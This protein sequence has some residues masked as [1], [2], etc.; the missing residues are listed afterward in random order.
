MA[1]RAIFSVFSAVIFM[2]ASLPAAAQDGG[3]DSILVLDASGSMWGQIEGEAKIT[4]AK[5]VLGDLLNDLPS[6]RRL[7]LIS[8]GHRRTGDCAD[9]EELAAIGAERGAIAS[10]VQKLNPKGKT[11][12]ADSIKLAADKLKY[13]ENKATVILVSDGIET[14]APDPCGVAAALEAAGADFT[15]HVVGFDVT[16]ENAQAQ[17][18]CIADNTGGQF[19]SASNAGELTQALEETVVAEVETV[20][21]TKVRLRATELEG[22]LVI[23]EGLTWTVTPAGGGDPVFTQDGAGVVDIEVEPGTYDIA[24]I[25]P[26]DGLKGEQK[27]F[28]VAE[29]TWKTVTIALT[30]PVEATVRAE[31]SGEG[32]AG[33]NV[34]VHWT[35]PDRRGDY[36]GIAEKGAD[37]GGYLSYRYTSQGNPVELRLPV[38]PGDYE[39]RYMLGRPIRVLASVDIKVTPATA[40]LAAP[41]TAIAG[42][43]VEVEFT[44]PP[45]GSGDWLTVA[46]PDAP[47][48]KYNDYRYS[49]DGSPVSLRMPLE[50]GEYELRFVQGGKKVLARKPITV[51]AALATIS[52][53][54]TATAGEEVSV[55]FTAPEAGSGDWITVAAPDAEPSKYND[56]HYTRQGSPG[57]VR[58]PLEPG[59]YELRVVQG[60]K[61]VLARRPITVVEAAATVTGPETA[62][63][64][65]EVSVDFTAPEA[66]SGDW[67]TV[68]AP[69]DPAN[70]YNDYHY[71]RSGSPGTV[72][73][74]LEPGAYELRVVQ[75]GKKVL[76]RQPITVTEA[77]ATLSAKDS[78]I[79]GETIEV[80]YTA[81][82]PSSGDWITVASPDQPAN[83]YSAYYYT[84]SGSPAKLR[85]PLEA[86]EYELR[87]IQS[88]KKVLATEAI[89]VTEATATMNAPASGKVNEIIKVE[90]TGP[91]PGP[92]D[93][94]VVSALGSPDAKYITYGYVSS[95]SPASVRMPKEPGDYELRYLQAN[96]KLLARRPIKATP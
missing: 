80:E 31:P 2:I 3:G 54:D 23:E 30:F 62:I 43:E 69:D 77:T 25:R 20:T 92:S 33:V 19:V 83:K 88:G 42:E 18:R 36:I 53:P 45:A 48:N 10:A 51:T 49:R 4:I 47:E 41:D 55:E 39:I 5:R 27:A 1:I 50:P 35:G 57:T 6:E 32:V 34:K 72:R 73:M 37:K 60:G 95:G 76:A 94:I 58:M 15:V 8:Y 44:G 64:G 87:V 40:T 9:I 12:M 29:N 71:T 70:K 68:A 90:F 28:K 26:S 59:D 24:V 22:G 46:K 7:G 81:P 66:S 85:M 63:A 56:Y 82:K 16:E 96:K 13:T 17:L 65:E 89:T 14:C 78:A 61:K 38:E 74:P 91:P 52:A 84:K 79:A 86:G 11:P 67:V 93:F 75:G 21:A